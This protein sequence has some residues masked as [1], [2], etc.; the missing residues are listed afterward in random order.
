MPE[1]FTVPEG[2][3]RSRAD[4]AL[5]TAFP[6]HSRVAWQ[7][8]LD[9]GHVKRDEQVLTRRDQVSA[10]DV[11]TYEA[12]EVTPL[13][14][15][16]ADIPLDVLFEDEQLLVVNKPAGMVVHPGA[17]TKGDTLVHALL[18]HCAGSLSGIGGVERPGIV[19]RLDRETTG[20]IVVAKTD[21]AHRGL[22]EQFAE[23]DLHKEYL[24][25]VSG[26]PR[27]LSGVVDQP[28]DRDKRHRHRMT[29]SEE[30]RP[31]R[32]DW[33]LVEKFDI[34]RVSLFRCLIHTG[35]T[36][37]VRVHMKSI[38]HPLVGDRTYGWR[39]HQAKLPVEAERV[40]LHAHKL[41]LVHPITEATLELEAPIPADMAELLTALREQ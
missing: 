38:G 20:A 37:Q 8:A 32:T 39:P 13:D 6:D 5:A 23:R 29:I 26:I 15:Q 9:G 27:L 25:L 22:A 14:L 11:I 1:T 18:S 24:A 10:G 34:S 40:M 2:V 7:R 12:P 17:G 41:T 28:I 4:K 31:A 16:P 21:A 3:Y 35:R 36:H 30:G 19:H 33:E